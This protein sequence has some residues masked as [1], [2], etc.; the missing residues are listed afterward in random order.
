[1]NS[2]EFDSFFRS[3]TQQ[4]EQ[5]ATRFAGQDAAF[6]RIQQQLQPEAKG[7]FRLHFAAAAAAILLLAMIGG[8][9]LQTNSWLQGNSTSSFELTS[10]AC[11][12][13]AAVDRAEAAN[14]PMAYASFLPTFELPEVEILGQ[15]FHM[16]S[17]QSVT[18]VVEP[19][20]E[21]AGVALTFPASLSSI[22]PQ[23]QSNFEARGH[24]GVAGNNAMLGVDMMFN[25][26][27]GKRTTSPQLQLGISTY[28]GLFPSNEISDAIT[29]TLFAEAGVRFPKKRRGGATEVRIGKAILSDNPVIDTDA[30]KVGLQHSLR[31]NVQLGP[32]V[33][34][35]DGKVYPGIKLTLG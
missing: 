13:F 12:F 26:P 28:H 15:R 11:D 3:A 35:T 7:S 25:I 30:L 14:V 31:H 22:T 16:P 9:Q 33:I 10:S 32:E 27:L 4:H 23:P 1:M 19:I 29:V 2:H 18:A 21:G 17:V 6:A 8:S 24:A 5:A 20:S 34:F